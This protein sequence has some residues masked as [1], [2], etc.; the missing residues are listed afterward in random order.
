MT[1]N[2]VPAAGATSGHPCRCECG[3]LTRVPRYPSDLTDQQWARLEPLLPVMLCDTE[4]GGRPEKHHRRTMIDAILYVADNGIKWRALPADFPPWKTVYHLFARWA[5]DGVAAAVTDRL[6]ALVR[7][8]AGRDPEPSAGVVD[9]Q[10]VHESAEG[11]VPA[12][13]SGF[14]PHKKVNGRK[15]HILTDTLGLLITAA[16]SPASAA[17]RDGAAVLLA[18]A[19]SRG[20][21]RLACIWADRAYEGPLLTWAEG[22][23]VTIEIV[24][25][26]PGQKGFR[27]LPR[28]WVVE[29]THAWITR[30][31]RCAR[32]YER[33]PNHHATWIHWAANIQMIRRLAPTPSPAG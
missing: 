13:S 16:V 17:D 31:R 14:D 19:R 10:S 1:L 29:R 21:T 28:R 8:E 32:D 3:C 30:R 27:V 11:V 5:A 25:R 20:R 22:I 9:A 15:R 2:R 18:C 26:P 6:R 33:L 7:A 4:L 12:A 23:G 24:A